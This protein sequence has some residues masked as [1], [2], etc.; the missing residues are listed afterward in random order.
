MRTNSVRIHVANL[1]TNFSKDL[2]QILSRLKSV[3]DQ[4]ARAP[5]N[6]FTEH[7][8][9]TCPTVASRKKLEKQAE[10]YKGSAKAKYF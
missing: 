8:P 7:S 4:L 3:G 10:S 1:S 6:L 2:Y 9:L 5:T